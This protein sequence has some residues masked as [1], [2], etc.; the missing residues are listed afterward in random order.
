MPN[1]LT[2][3]RNL[4]NSRDDV[5]SESQRQKLTSSSFTA[6]IWTISGVVLVACGNIEDFL[7]IDDGG[8]GGGRSVHVQSSAVQGARIYFDTDGGGV[9]PA[10]RTAQDALYPEGFITD[11]TGE[12]RGIPAEFYGKPFIAD[13]R[14]AINVETGEVLSGTLRSIP[15]AA[16]DHL[17]ASP[18]TEYIESEG[19]DPKEV[20]ADLINQDAESAEV[21]AQIRLILDSRSY[22]GGNENIEALSVFL[23][24]ENSPTRDDAGAFLVGD[25]ATQNP[26]TLFI[27]NA[28]ADDSTTDITKTIGADT[29]AG[30]NIATIHAVSHGDESVRYSFVNADGTP[31]NVSDYIIEGGVISVAQGA[32]LSAETTELHVSVSN[33]DS[34]QIVK[35]DVTIAPA[36]ELTATSGTAGTI[37]ENVLGSSAEPIL[38]GIEASGTV[39]ATDFTISDALGLAS[40]VSYAGMFDIVAAGD[41][42]NLVLIDTAMLDFE[43]IPGG[44][45]NLRVH[46]EPSDHAPSNILEIAVTVTDDPDD[47]AFSGVVR[48]EVTEDG[49]LVARGTF[50]VANQPQNE[51][52]TVSTQGTYGELL[53]GA[54]GT[55]TYTLDNDD[56]TVQQL[57]E[58]QLLIDTAELELTVGGDSVTQ[59]ISIIINGANEDVRFEDANNA[60]VSAADVP[61]AMN[62]EIGTTAMLNGN[63]ALGNIFMDLGISLEGQ[64]ATSSDPTVEFAPSVSAD[65]RALF[66]LSA[67][68]DLEF[69]GT[70]A[71]ALVLGVSTHTLDLLVSAPE[72]TTEQIPL[73]LQ[74]NIVNNDDDG[75]AEYEITGDVEANQILTVSRVQGTEEDPDGVVGAVVFQWFRGDEGTSNFALLG[76]GSTYSVTQADIASGDS[77]GVFVR[78]T[79]GSGTTYTNTD[80][81]DATTI[82]VFASPISFTSPAAGAA[83]T[84]NLDEDT[85]ISTT[86]AHFTVQ[87]RSEDDAGAMVDIDNY[88]LLDA[89]NMPTTTYRGF[90]IDPDSGAITLTGSLD[91]EDADADGTRIILRVRAT[92]MNSPAETATITLTVNVDDVNDNS[93]IFVTAT[94]E[95]GLSDGTEM[96]DENTGA[97]TVFARVRATDDDGTAMYSTVTY[98]ITAGNPGNAFAINEDTG[99]IRVNGALDYE[100]ATFYTL[101]ITASDNQDGS[102]DAV[103]IITVNIGDVNDN[104]PM[105]TAD[106]D[107]IRTTTGNNDDTPTGYSI[108]VT[109]ADTVGTLMVNSDDPSFRFDRAGANSDTWNLILLA[110]EAITAG[111]ISIGYTA[112][113]GANPPVTGTI[114]LTAVD[115]PVEFAPIADPMDLMTPEN[116][117]TWSL[118]VT[119]TSLGSDSDGGNSAISGYDILE[120]RDAS[121]A[122]VANNGVFSITDAGLISISGALDHETSASYAIDIQATDT[123]ESA[124]P[125]DMAETGTTTLTVTVGDVEEGSAEYEI[126]DNN[127]ALS[128]ALVDDDSTSA[129]YSEDPDGVVG[130]VSYQWFKI[131]TDGTRTDVGT[132]SASYTIAAGDEDLVHG[133]Y[134]GYTDGFGTVYTHTDNDPTTTIEVI[135]S[136]IE[137]SQAPVDIDEDQGPTPFV[138]LMPTVDGAQSGHSFSFAYVTGTDSSLT[139]LFEITTA[140]D[141]LSATIKVGGTLDRDVTGGDRYVLPITITYDPDGPSSTV[142]KVETRNVNVVVNVGDVNDNEAEFAENTYSAS[143]AEDATTGPAGTVVFTVEA[144]DADATPEYSNV[145]YAIKGGTGM[146]LFDIDAETGEIRAKS[147]ARL[148]FDATTSTPNPIRSYSLEIIARD[149]LDAMGMEA[150]TEEDDTTTVTIR[151]DD[152]NDNAPDI[153]VADPSPS[154]TERTASADTDI[155]TGITVTD[156]DSDKTYAQGDF[157]LTGDSRFNFVWDATAKTGSVVLTSGSTIAPNTTISLSLTVT[158]ANPVGHSG[159]DTETL[160][161]TVEAKPP[162]GATSGTT[163]T[164]MQ[165]DPSAVDASGTLVLDAASAQQAKTNPAASE[166]TITDGQYGT[167]TVDATGAWTYNVDNTNDAVKALASGA[168]LTDT[169]TIGVPL[170][171]GGT[172][173]VDVTVTITGVTVVEGTANA[174]VDPT[175]PATT[176]INPVNRDTA[177]AFEVIQGS[178][179]DDVITVGAEG[180]VVFGGYGDDTIN[181]RNGKTDIVV[182]R[183]SS[184][185]GNSWRADDGGDTINNFERGTDIF[186]F[187]DDDAT[188]ISDLATFVS[189]ATSPFVPSTVTD[190]N[191]KPVFSSP[192][193]NSMFG[194]LLIK[195]PAVYDVDGPGVL[196]TPTTAG[197]TIN[198]VDKVGLTAA[199]TQGLVNNAM[200]DGWDNATTQI[201]DPGNIENWL[202]TDVDTHVGLVVM[203]SDELAIDIL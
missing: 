141:T 5:R 138:T 178:D 197:I 73:N 111:P 102:I 10:E 72:D 100:A 50:S 115:T 169:F 40:G 147:G 109:D 122:V 134:I 34:T 75:R 84:I 136:P 42:W 99:E 187:V 39:D 71:E 167:A 27:A 31:A 104:A 23:A 77:I 24:E 33:G 61:D 131:E 87:A 168:T 93:P 85:G 156:G 170:S 116:A 86:T 203:T 112:T 127:G 74:V 132:D 21:Q 48:G 95:N 160:T 97:G 196:T 22:L 7:G 107:T 119:A 35:I 46:V 125:G 123:P 186:I 144:T 92:D 13:L 49:N 137:F 142:G 67:S 202:T 36:V 58:R 45:I 108:T 54:S 43:T 105:V 180:A 83:R 65:L 161:I 91:Y 4:L 199:V 121:G 70:N 154:V 3:K 171:A 157:E 159:T 30:T 29:A 151:I 106:S 76:T 195:F 63:F 140:A 153:V 25:D 181:L 118:Q 183:F 145:R 135:T 148:N 96:V 110:N 185:D 103:E 14:D 68:G 81:V 16:G 158:D 38:T 52:V 114:T 1:D 162:F 8:G 117:D 101:T 150:L 176:P 82:A 44:V 62:I 155:I 37:A 20:V 191:E 79:D 66:D 198:W 94:P 133:V 182:Y 129:N 128:V 179:E 90:T 47:I 59:S 60:R 193:V 189:R 149:G 177:T 139:N 175:P 194:E 26:E 165:Y 57:L 152:V 12:A 146:S 69:T 6:S 64:L 28:D 51:D 113:D 56:P 143:V 174:D 19:G 80:G 172:G 120:V 98:S 41:T 9:G 164:A 190:I 55:W 18:I 53:L 2:A 130:D 201:T 184:I 163:G 17:L 32:T 126:T 192:L 124:V 200:G 89:N 166:Y 88:M 11:A 15:N 188:P 173:D 78:Y